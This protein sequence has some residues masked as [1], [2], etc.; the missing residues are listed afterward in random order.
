MFQLKQVSLVVHV[1][2]GC[3]AIIF[4]YKNVDALNDFDG[5]VRQVLGDN[6]TAGIWAT[7]PKPFLS[8]QSGLGDQVIYS[9]HNIVLSQAFIVKYL[10]NPSAVGVFIITPGQ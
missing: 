1:K 9:N 8:L 5:G 7:Y 3:N 10:S 4:C 2:F 6:G